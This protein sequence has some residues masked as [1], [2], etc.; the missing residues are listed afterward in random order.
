MTA[1]VRQVHDFLSTFSTPTPRLA[2]WTLSLKKESRNQLRDR[3]RTITMLSPF[4]IKSL[5]T[6]HLAETPHVSHYWPY[7]Q[8][9]KDDRW[10]RNRD[11]NASGNSA[12]IHL[13]CC[14]LSRV[15]RSKPRHVFTYIVP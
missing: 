3:T 7:L 5:R 1:K 13:S 6:L 12:D 11:I 8:L 14:A 15:V 4:K 10:R 9:M 2:A